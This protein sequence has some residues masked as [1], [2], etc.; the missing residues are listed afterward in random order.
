MKVLITGGSRGIGKEISKLYSQNNHIVISPTRDEM[1]L[2][3]INSI[4]SYVQKNQD[5][6]IDAIINNAGVNPLNDITDITDD[7]LIS[8]IQINL[9]APALLCRSFVNG[10]KKRQFG[11]IVN[12]G[13]I[14]SVVSK[15][16]RSVYSMSKNGMHG[17]TNTLA[18]ELG[19]YGILANTVCPGFTKTKLTSKNISIDAEKELV[20]NIPLGRFASPA[21][22]AKIVYMLGSDQN[23]YI[24]GQK[25]IVDGGFSVI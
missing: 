14:W 1:N 17:L 21:E 12:I 5:L 23:T 11:R 15:E 22:I 19:K 4:K 10:M 8:C 7:E 6:E 20:K 13:S 9:L 25:I 3:D 18:V 2:S 16:K 24:T